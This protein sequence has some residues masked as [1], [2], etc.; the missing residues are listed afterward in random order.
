MQCGAMALRVT[1]VVL[2]L[3]QPPCL[4]GAPCHNHYHHHRHH[5]HRQNGTT[6]LMDAVDG[7]Q[8]AFVPVLLK[9]GADVTCVNSVR[10]GW[11]TG[12]VCLDR[13]PVSNC[14]YTRTR[15]HTHTTRAHTRPSA[16]A[17]HAWDDSVLCLPRF[18]SPPSCAPHTV[19]RGRTAL[20]MAREADCDNYYDGDVGDSDEE[21]FEYA[22]NMQALEAKKRRIVGAVEQVHTATCMD[23]PPAPRAR[24]HT[25][26]HAHTRA[27]SR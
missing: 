15:T 10:G 5:H 18:V 4:T 8:E 26:M 1:R 23:P 3:R 21:D 6:P 12:G 17:S 2:P 16:A 7:G 14:V 13:V 25:Y 19:Q 9:A 22:N 24:S 20:D 11:G 27:R